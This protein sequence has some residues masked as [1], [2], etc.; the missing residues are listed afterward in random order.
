M[1]TPLEL[2]AAVAIDLVVGDPKS[3]PHPVRAIG[4]LVQKTER[5]LRRVMKGAVRELLAGVVLVVWVCFVVLASAVAIEWALKGLGRGTVASII[6][7]AL[8]LWLLATTLAIKGLLRAARAVIEA[9]K[10]EQIETA[11]RRLSMIVGRDT[12]SLNKEGILK[13]T[14]ETVS[15]N[16][17]DGI[18]APMF[19]L[20]I[21]GFPLAMLYKAVNTMDSMVGYRNERYLYFGWAAARTDD[22]LNY[23]PAR[24]TG[25]MI[26]LAVG[27]IRVV[28]RGG[29][30]LSP[31]YALMVMFRDGRK[32]PSPNS[33]VPEAAMAG[34][35]GVE[36][37][38][39]S[40]YN[41][42]LVEKPSIGEKINHDY[43]TAAEQ[44]LYITL[45]SSILATSLGA[46]CL[47]LI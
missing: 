34:A 4:W 39:P 14:I 41:G 45:V 27:I 23:I 43:L 13:A 2:V 22:I 47:W 12:E 19:Y 33:G 28:I 46:L 26:V 17:S 10:E 8:F 40:L 32:H 38:G 29:R 35:L 16:L 37:G 21:G 9:T 30:L 24:L 7:E 1:I 3:L 15:E 20:V 6:A 31:A 36:L 25:A 11:R 44:A 18:V 5:L 42:M